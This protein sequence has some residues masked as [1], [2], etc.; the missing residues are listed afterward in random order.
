[1][2]IDIQRYIRTSSVFVGN[3]AAPTPAVEPTPPTP[4]DPP[5]SGIRFEPANV[6]IPASGQ[7]SG[8]YEVSDNSITV[9]TPPESTTDSMILWYSSTPSTSTEDV[10]SYSCTYTGAGGT[11]F[12]IGLAQPPEDQPIG[13]QLQAFVDAGGSTPVPGL[14]NAIGFIGPLFG[15]TA[16]TQLSPTGGFG[17]NNPITLATGDVFIVQLNKATSVMT[18]TVNGNLTSTLTVSSLTTRD[19]YYPTFSFSQD[20]P[21]NS[22][23]VLA[24]DFTGL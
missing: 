2:A 10:I 15:V 12:N 18:L 3:Q 11:G 17:T 22:N 9:T 7:N 14:F 24:F 6:V 5:A 19:D 16:V 23:D 20:V 13:E 1:M 4:P 21:Q 8:V